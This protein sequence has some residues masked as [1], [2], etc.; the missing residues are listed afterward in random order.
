MSSRRMIDRVDCT[1]AG[2][3]LMA[4]HPLYGSYTSALPP[5]RNLYRGHSRA[6]YKLVPTALR[7]VTKRGISEVD[8]IAEEIGSIGDFYRFADSAGLEIPGEGIEARE[9]F[10]R[11]RH[12]A[13]L[14]FHVTNHNQEWPPKAIL[15]LLAIAQHHGIPTRLLDWTRDSLVAAYFAAVSAAE[16]VYDGTSHGP[17][18]DD[19]LMCVWVMH[20]E[21]IDIT[22]QASYG[23]LKPDLVGKLKFVTTATSNNRNLHLQKGVFT[24]LDTTKTHLGKDV[25]DYTSEQPLDDYLRGWEDRLT[26][27][28]NF[29]APLTCVTLP[30]D[31]APDLLACLAHAGVTG[32]TIYAGFGGVAA[33]VNE[34]R[35]YRSV[36]DGR[37]AFNLDGTNPIV[38][39]KDRRSV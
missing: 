8:Q 38:C 25:P 36:I 18:P 17:D 26:I 2:E 4:L 28:P 33:A 16:R 24:L 30:G 14:K 7:G 32:S 19:S 9:M 1:S 35:L 11:L 22:C 13:K 20:W 23:A 31:K 27:E 3:F 15:P 21:T 34:R 37:G 29:Q 5:N 39:R 10:D 12:Q 6:S